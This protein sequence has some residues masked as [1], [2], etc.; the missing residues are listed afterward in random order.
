[1]SGTNA[2]FVVNSGSTFMVLGEDAVLAAGQFYVGRL[3]LFTKGI[4]LTGSLRATQSVSAVTF[5]SGT[6]N[7]SHLIGGRTY[8]QPG[9]NITTGGTE[10]SPIVSLSPDLTVNS[11]F[12]GL[13]ISGN[14]TLSNLFIP[15]GL[16][17]MTSMNFGRA[18]G[19]E[20]VFTA[21]TVSDT[22]IRSDSH[23]IF[24]VIPSDDHPDPEDASLDCVTFAESDIVN[25]TSFVI[26][27]RAERGTWGTYD[28]VYKIVR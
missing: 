14:T 19:L 8:V 3:A 6:T 28:V 22:R 21:T 23:V 11:I 4:D 18:E 15:L 25:G 12:A 13:Y 10:A 24:K 9:T 17:G 7:L 5:F 20:G 16:T 2:T 1:M 26:N 27:A